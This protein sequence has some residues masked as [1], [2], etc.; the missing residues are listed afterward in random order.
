VCLLGGGKTQRRLPL[1]PL[2]GKPFPLFGLTWD[3]SRSFCRHDVQ[4]KE[5]LLVGAGLLYSAKTD[6]AGPSRVADD[7][8][9]IA[10]SKLRVLVCQNIRLDVPEG[11]LGLLVNAIVE[12]LQNV[13]LKVRRTRIL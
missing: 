4:R 1:A 13:F 10:T 3:G 9:E 12:R 2:F 7:T 11:C 5:A 8:A 6:L